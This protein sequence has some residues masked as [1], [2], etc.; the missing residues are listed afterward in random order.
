M[1]D[2]GGG[3]LIRAEVVAPGRTVGPRAIKAQTRCL[4]TPAHLGS[5]RERAVKR[6]FVSECVC[7]CVPIRLL[8][9]LLFFYNICFDQRITYTH[10]HTQDWSPESAFI[11]LLKTYVLSVSHFILYVI[12]CRSQF[13]SL[14]S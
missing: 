11:C 3:S 7:V 13:H 14:V 4:L 2:V 5:P 8:Q 10:T 6:L 12:L 1:G 9:L